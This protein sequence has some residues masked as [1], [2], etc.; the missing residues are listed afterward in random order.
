MLHSS[1]SSPS[2]HSQRASLDD[3]PASRKTKTPR[4]SGDGTRIQPQFRILSESVRCFVLP[5][6]LSPSAQADLYAEVQ[7]LGGLTADMEYTNL[8]LT[9]LRAPKRVALALRREQEAVGGGLSDEWVR[10]I[11]VLH[12]DWLRDTRQRRIMQGY[13]EYYVLPPV[14]AGAG[15][16][17]GQGEAKEGVMARLEAAE[18]AEAE[19]PATPTATPKKRGRP[20]RAELEARAAAVSESTPEPTPTP[21]PKRTPRKP[22]DADVAL[23]PSSIALG[24]GIPPWQNSEYACQ[25]PTPLVSLHNQGLVDELEVIRKQ[26]ALT[27][28]PWSERSYGGCLSALK[29]YPAPIC[30]LDPK[31]IAAL[32]GVGK[33]M[34]GLIEQYCATGRIVEAEQIRQD[35]ANAVLFSLMHLYGVG[36]VAARSLYEAGCRSHEDVIARGKSLATQLRVQDCLAILPDLTQPIPRA[37]VAAIGKLVQAQ[38]DAVLPGC[39]VEISGG[40]RRGKTMSNDVDLLICHPEHDYS[41]RLDVVQ[42][43]LEQM[44]KRGIMSHTVNITSPSGNYET[45]GHIDVAEIVVLP[46]AGVARGSDRPRH[47][48]VDLVFCSPKVYGAVQLGWT[49]SKTF[50]KDI[51]RWA[52]MKGYKFHSTGLREANTD[53]VLETRTE[54]EV[55]DVL[56]L[57]YV[58]PEWRNCDA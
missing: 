6:K 57:E 5:D 14:S 22:K 49:G 46:P 1:S 39:S 10:R 55:F 43:L 50:E 4:L 35:P 21:T 25:R 19:A 33:K 20:S 9:S 54:S 18:S 23:L 42:Q 53:R 31:R 12:T 44:R 17:A 26:R 29:A 32:K 2:S 37:E 58:P 41:K 11:P 48:R 34:L 47:R 52:Q 56:G 40:Y 7:T 28:Q 30:S 15:A 8:I 3:P 13:E 51:R 16:G 36:P 27:S 24:S 45:S 38:V